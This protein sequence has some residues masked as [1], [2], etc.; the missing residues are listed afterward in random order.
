LWLEDAPVQRR[1]RD[2]GF[3]NDGRSTVA[4]LVYVDD[5]L[6]QFDQS[7][8]CAVFAAVEAEAEKLR[9]YLQEQDGGDDEKGEKHVTPLFYCVD[10]RVL[11]GRA[12]QTAT[13]KGRD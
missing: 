8:G 1:G 13:K 11:D 2:S 3:K 10:S 12:R 5:S 4:E 9:G 6:R 7:A